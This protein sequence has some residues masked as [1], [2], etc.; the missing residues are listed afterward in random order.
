MND[1]REAA[2]DD[3]P[4]LED[5]VEAAP[6]AEPARLPN[7][8]LFTATTD[9]TVLRERLLAELVPAL[10]EMTAA[11]EAD[12]RET[13]RQR[14]EALIAEKLPEILARAFEQR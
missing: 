13:L 1:S 12:F 6:A 7:L 10:E 2:P 11:L 5:I 9:L 3:I 4:E 8:D 14:S